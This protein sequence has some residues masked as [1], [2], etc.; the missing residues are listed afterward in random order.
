MLFIIHTAM[1][2]LTNFTPTILFEK[3]YTKRLIK[4]VSVFIKIVK[5]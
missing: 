2:R 5:K 3:K 1:T 4:L